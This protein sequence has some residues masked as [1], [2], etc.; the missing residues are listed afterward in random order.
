M[1]RNLLDEVVCDV[2]CR[3]GFEREVL[4]GTEVTEALM[5]EI[6]AKDLVVLGARK[7]GA[8][9]QLLFKSVPEE[10]SERVNNTVVIIKK[11]SPVRRGR[12]ERLLTGTAA[13]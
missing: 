9:E 7:G 3:R 10:I 5:A 4:H 12:L 6:Q 11:Y 8:W 13:S 1:A 2:E